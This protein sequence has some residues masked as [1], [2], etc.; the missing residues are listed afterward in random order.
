MYYYYYSIPFP[1]NSDSKHTPIRDAVVLLT[2]S[3]CNKIK[4]GHSIGGKTIY[5]LFYGKI[6]HNFFKE[7]QTL[8]DYK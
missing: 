4:K 7:R 8:S 6:A 1:F 5:L 2:P 3:S